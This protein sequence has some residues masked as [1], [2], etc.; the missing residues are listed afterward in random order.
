MNVSNY[1]VIGPEN[2]KGR[3]VADIIRESVKAGFSA[4]QIRSKFASAR[5]LIDLLRESA[6][7]IAEIDKDVLLFVDDRL[8]VCYA[9]RETGIKVDGIHVG[10]SDIPVNICRK[11]L[12]KKAIIG[13]TPP[14]GE[15]V[16]Y[17]KN[18]GNDMPDYFGIGPLHDTETKKDSGIDKFGKKNILTLDEIRAIKDNSP[19]PVIVGGGVKADDL[20]DLKKTGV[21]GYFVVSAV[22]GAENPGKAAEEMVEVWREV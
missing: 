21:D 9:A 17:I 16:D 20:R 8:D 4:V 19:V 10:Q 18:I 14:A 13:L 5:E 11:L 22:A 15:V 3:A 7:I 12:G 1:L 6:N 2:T